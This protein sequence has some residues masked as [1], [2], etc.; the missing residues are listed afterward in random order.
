MPPTQSETLSTKDDVIS[1]PS[2]LDNRTLALRPIIKKQ[3][4]PVKVSRSGRIVKKNQLDSQNKHVRRDIHANYVH[5]DVGMLY[6]VIAQC[7]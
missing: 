1:D 7:N 2:V 4:Q 5:Y 3:D 6:L